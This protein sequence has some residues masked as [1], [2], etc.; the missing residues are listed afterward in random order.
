MG[1][2]SATIDKCCESGEWIP[3][4][5]STMTVNQ[6]MRCSPAVL[7]VVLTA[8]PALPTESAGVKTYQSVWINSY[9]AGGRTGSPSD[10]K[11]VVP[12]NFPASY[13][14]P[15]SM[16]LENHSTRYQSVF[17][18]SAS[19][20]VFKN[21]CSE[22]ANLLACVSAGSGGNFSEFP[23]CN[24]DPRTTSFS[25]LAQVDMGPNNSGSQSMT[26]RTTGLGLSLNIFYCGIGDTFAL[27]V[28]PGADPTDCIQH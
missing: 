2:Y 13:C 24:V 27:G 26:W 19:V 11:S 10:S 20:L 7:L 16:I 18:N 14:P 17:S 9:W 25:R 5:G 4:L 6:A 15:N 21:T 23:I 22:S 8:C 1:S 3:I 12:L 28:V